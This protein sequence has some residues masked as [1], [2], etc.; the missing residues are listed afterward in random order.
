[1]AVTDLTMYF[2]RIWKILGLW[3]RNIM[4]WCKQI[5]MGHPGKSLE[6][7]GLW[8]LRPRGFRT[9]QFWQPI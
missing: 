4:E 8:R 3:T 5:L 2:G 1:M 6:L 7:C 9:E